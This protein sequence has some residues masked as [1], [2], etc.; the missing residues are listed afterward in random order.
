VEQFICF[1]QAEGFLKTVRY[2]E[3]IRKRLSPQTRTTIDELG[4]ISADDMAQVEPGHVAKPVPNSYWNLA[5]AVYAYLF[6][7]MTKS[8]EKEPEKSVMGMPPRGDI[9]VLN[10]RLVKRPAAARTQ[11]LEV[12]EPKVRSSRR[13]DGRAQHGL[14]HGS[15]NTS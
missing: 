7:E 15:S 8:P 12:C 6:G 2:V 14:A 1:D 11:K 10:R 4:V 3:S 9:L 5:G 13:V